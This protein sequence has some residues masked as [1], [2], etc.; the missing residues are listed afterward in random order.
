M[1]ISNTITKIIIIRKTTPPI[2]IPAIAPSDK[3]DIG[4]GVVVGCTTVILV[5]HILL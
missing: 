5:N 1:K 4:V 2:T 3:G